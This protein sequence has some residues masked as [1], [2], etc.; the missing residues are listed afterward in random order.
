M[1][2]LAPLEPQPEAKYNPQGTPASAP[3]S[4]GMSLTDILSQPDGSQ[5]KLPIPQSVPKVAVRD[6]LAPAE[7]YISTSLRSVG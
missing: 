2:V 6:L 3:R 4:K 5:R 1:P 7:G